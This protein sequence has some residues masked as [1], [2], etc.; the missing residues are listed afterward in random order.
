MPTPR[1][2]RQRATSAF[3]RI[4]VSHHGS[5]GRYTGSSVSPRQ[6]RPGLLSCPDRFTVVHDD[7]HLFG[8]A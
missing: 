1:Y 4:A 5:G 8:V 3:T 7:V 2:R 6:P